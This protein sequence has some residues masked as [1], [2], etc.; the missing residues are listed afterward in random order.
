MAIITR[1]FDD[2]DMAERARAHVHNLGLS[3]VE[4]SLLGNE[5]LR[6]RYG[7]D[8]FD[9]SQTASGTATG[10]G[11]GAV[12]G[13]GAGLL[14]GLGMLAIPGI[15]PLVAAGWL[16]ATAAGA[17]GGAMVGGAIGALADIGVSEEEA[18]VFHEAMRRGSVAL[19]VRFPDAHRPQ[20]EAA[21]DQVATANFS[22]LRSRYEAEGWRHDQAEAERQARLRD[23]ML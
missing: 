9:A 2:F 4:T 15:G 22:E 21:L 23:P 20:I 5:N 17:V 1:V 16:A 19:T 3:D 6:D 7:A 10:A 18:P 11:V 8:R 13:G 12:A 14:A